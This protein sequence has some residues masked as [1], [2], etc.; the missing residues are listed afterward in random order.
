MLNHVPLII[1]DDANRDDAALISAIS[2]KWGFPV[3]SSSEKHSEGL[4][5]Q[6]QN[7]VLGLADAGEKKVNPVE[8]D[9]ASPAS[10][11]RKQH[12]GG[13]KEPI[14]KAIGLKG[15]EAWHVVDATPG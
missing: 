5:L 14:V 11:Y 8:V 10:L 1:C 13:R 2:E 12:G 7:G 9:F 15:N 3:V 4:Y 6:V